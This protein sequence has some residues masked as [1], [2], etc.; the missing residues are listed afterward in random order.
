MLFN[1]FEFVFL[2]LPIA[3]LLYFLLNKFGHA[4]LAKAWL[5]AAS[6]FFYSYWNVKYLPLMLVSL[7]V[8]YFIGMRLVK[9]KSK[10]LLTVGLI[11]N[12]GM[13]S[14][15]KYYDFFLQ[16]VNALIGTHFTLLSLTLPLAIS[17]YTFQ[18]IAFLVDTYRG[19]TKACHFLDYALFVTFFPQLIAGPIVHHAQIM[20]QFADSSKKRWQSKYIVLG[21]FVFAVGIF[22]K[23]GIAD[24]LSPLVHEGF[25]VQQSLTFVEAWLSS[26]A[27]TFQLYFDFSGYSDMAIG[28]AL[29]FNIKLPQNFNSPYKAVNIQDFWHR[30]HMTLSQFLTKYVYISLGGNR[31]GI[32]RTYANIMIVFL[33]SGLWHG[34][35]WTFV[36]WGFLHGLA[37]VIHRLWS[38]A[39]GRMPAFAGWFVTFF[40]INITWVFF[41][42]TSMHDAV[43]VLKGMFG[44]NGI[45]LANSVFPAFIIE[46]LQ[47]LKE[48]GV[49]FSEGYHVS[50]LDPKMVAYIFG[51]LCISF[52]LKNSIQL[53]DSFRPNVWTAL[54]TAVL[55]V[56]S[57]LHL[58]SISE[59]LYFNF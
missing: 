2:F 52:F 41:R 28:I 43:K 19:E 47:F 29:M 4:T 53:K 44:L 35:G 11:F 56:Y 34:A 13:L 27:F 12:I 16:N 7:I 10:L 31:K 37:S 38:K 30:W 32:T 33:I 24:V 14:Y 23:V 59:F 21:I 48:Y 58:T 26:L 25:D 3:F 54:F 22:K 55:L 20:P 39:G 45:E 18:K 17:F 1:S 6:L 9:H 5:V 50:L 46:K 40:F 51:A 49:S 36:F 8:N 42:A 57:V 15:F